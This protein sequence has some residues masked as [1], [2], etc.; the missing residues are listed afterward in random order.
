MLHKPRFT[1]GGL[2]LLIFMIALF[3][4]FWRVMARKRP[5]TVAESSQITLGMSKSQ[6]NWRLVGPYR[7]YATQGQVAWVFEYADSEA[8]PE[9]FFTVTFERGKVIDIEQSAK[10]IS[11]GVRKAI[12]ERRPPAL[13]LGILNQF[14]FGNL[15]TIQILSV[16]DASHCS[17][18]SWRLS[19]FIERQVP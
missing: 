18:K 1:L 14:E 5:I 7:V 3:L 13:F 15:T 9:K 12:L 17:V 11:D 6:V 2:L 16:S 19:F 8:Q 4:G 10:P